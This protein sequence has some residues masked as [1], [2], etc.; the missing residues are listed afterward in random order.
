MEELEFRQI[1]FRCEAY[2]NAE[3]EASDEASCSGQQNYH[4]SGAH[5][6]VLVWGVDQHLPLGCTNVHPDHQVTY[7]GSKRYAFDGAV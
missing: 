6:Q 5:L 4:A 7:P 3:D 1:I 2:K